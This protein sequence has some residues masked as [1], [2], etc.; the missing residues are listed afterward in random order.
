MHPLI[1]RLD[2]LTR[3]LVIIAL[4]MGA[5]PFTILADPPNGEPTPAPLS[6]SATPEPTATPNT[7]D[8]AP[9]TLYLPLIV[10]KLGLKPP[11]SGGDVP[12]CR[13]AR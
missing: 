7:V 2:R 11:P 5:F 13:A 12:T 4:L 9:N 6:S 8:T 1:H 10:C 3:I